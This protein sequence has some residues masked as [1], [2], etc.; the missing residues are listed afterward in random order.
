MQSN[1]RRDTKLELKVRSALHK[2]GLRFRVDYP[3]FTRGH[4]ADIVFTRVR[5]AVFLDGCFWHGCPLHYI[6]PKTNPGYWI[7][8]IRGNS[9]RDRAITEEL[10]NAGW[11]V[12]RYWEHEDL[13]QVVRQISAEVRRCL[14]SLGR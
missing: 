11:I 10:Q 7:P 2:D 1:R 9:N 6:P 3:P 8:K 14:E 13:D 5:I 12:L 4:R